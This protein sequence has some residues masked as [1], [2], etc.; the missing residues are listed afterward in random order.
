MR[1]F[2]KRVSNT[3]YFSEFVEKNTLYVRTNVVYD[4]IL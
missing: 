3:M 4:V 1:M 2:I